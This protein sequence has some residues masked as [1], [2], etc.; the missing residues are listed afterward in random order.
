MM[1]TDSANTVCSTDLDVV[2]VCLISLRGSD[3]I[4]SFS[5]SP[6][7][8]CSPTNQPRWLE[9]CNILTLS[10]SIRNMVCLLDGDVG[11]YRCDTGDDGDASVTQVRMV[12]QVR[13]GVTQVTMVTQVCTGVT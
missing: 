1:K 5:A 13:T 2:T 10:V 6:P 4:I 12:T 9:Q 3:L 7:E 8:I 11:V